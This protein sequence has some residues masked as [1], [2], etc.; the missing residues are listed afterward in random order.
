MLRIILLLLPIF[1]MNCSSSPKSNDLDTVFKKMSDTEYKN[2]INSY[3]KND[4]KYSGMHNTYQVFTTIINSTID[5]ALLQREGYFMQWTSE[6]AQRER[7]KRFQQ[8]SA[9]SKFFI[10][11]FTPKAD[12]ND[13]HRA[14]SM[15]KIYLESNGQKYQGSVRQQKLKLSQLTNLYP[16]H[17]RFNKAYIVEFNVPM[18]AVEKSEATLI[19]TSS[20]GNS[21]FKF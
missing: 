4:K 8:R 5:E 9:V 18:S 10:S 16:Y 12:Y 15:W 20:L 21:V 1:L 13:L 3:S 19:I 2:I 6:T 7:E 17:S 11:M 14:N